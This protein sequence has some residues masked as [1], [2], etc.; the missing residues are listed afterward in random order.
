MNRQPE[1]FPERVKEVRRQIR[2]TQE[3][4]AYALDVS[5]ATENR[6]ENGRTVPSK[7]A[8]RQFE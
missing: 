7:L 5:F 4:L 2:L 1:N 8:L 3:E 6:L